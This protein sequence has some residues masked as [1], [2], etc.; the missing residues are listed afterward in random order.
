MD[1]LKLTGGARIGFANATWPLATLTVNK[2]Q[3]EINASIIGN[4]IFR[5]ADIISIETYSEFPVIGQG[6]KINHRVE[7]YNNKVI[8]WTFNDP[9]SVISQIKQTGFLNTVS[10]E[11]SANDQL[12]IDKQSSGGFPLKIPAVVIAV[13]LWNILFLSDIMKFF[14][15]GKV[16]FP[17][18]NGAMIAVG[19]LFS[20]SILTL[21]SEG[22][23]KLI[24]KEGRTI[25]DIRSS[26]YLLILIS[27][28][29]FIGFLVIK[30]I[31]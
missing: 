18:G 2:D 4:L 10:G 19:L 5:P 21:I 29:M 11:I 13:V 8:F 9:S 20:T 7:N 14:N 23:S 25:E 16:G 12:I 24:L 30:S 6:I 1:H 26:L 31:S 15:S 28:F 22:F 27:G 17:L 3:L